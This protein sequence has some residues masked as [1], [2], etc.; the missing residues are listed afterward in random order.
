MEIWSI[1]GSPLMNPLVPVEFGYFYDAHFPHKADAVAA[2]KVADLKRR[3]EN[4]ERTK[5]SNAC[6]GM[7]TG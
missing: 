5:V 6:H 2:V 3:N 1:S 4:G 7:A